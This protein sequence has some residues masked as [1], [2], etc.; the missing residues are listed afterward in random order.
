M[1]EDG[2]WTSKHGQ[3]EV[4]GDMQQLCVQLNTP[5]EQRY[6]WMYRFVSCNNKQGMEAIGQFITAAV[7]LKVS[8]QLAVGRRLSNAYFPQALDAQSLP[9]EPL[10]QACQ[11]KAV[12]CINAQEHYPHEPLDS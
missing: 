7:C 6:D 3:A 8:W 1:Q 11:K 12:S 10:Q 5:L 9:W 4:D 2:S